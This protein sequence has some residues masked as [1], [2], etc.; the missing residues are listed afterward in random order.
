[1]GCSLAVAPKRWFA[2]AQVARTYYEV[3]L[4]HT[5]WAETQYD[6]AAGRYRRTDFGFAVVLGN[7]VLLTRG[8]YDASLAGVEKDVLRD[9]TLATIKHFSASNVLAGGTEWGKT[10]FWDTTFQSYFVLAARLLWPDLDA[11]TRANV[12]AIARGQ[13]DVH[14]LA[15][16]RERPAFRQLDAERP[17]RRPPRRHQAGG[18]GRLRAGARARTG[19]ARRRTWLARGVR[20]LEPQRGRTARRRPRQSLHS[21]RHADLGQHRH[22]PARHVHRREPRLVRP[23]LPGRTLAHLRPQRRALPAR[24]TAAARGADQA[25]QRGTVVAHHPRHDERRR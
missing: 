21:G 23:A 22:E 13:A 24:R 14:D 15:R 9:H 2:Q 6:S 1:M 19:L 8:T 11:R 4:R 5:R 25:T 20:P 3:L 10:L 17:H 18:D 16:H 12:E 7:A